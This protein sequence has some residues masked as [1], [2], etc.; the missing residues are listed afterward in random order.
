MTQFRIKIYKEKMKSDIRTQ[1]KIH[2]G[3]RQKKVGD[4]K[5]NF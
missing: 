5:L 4:K 3:N 2:L 1:K